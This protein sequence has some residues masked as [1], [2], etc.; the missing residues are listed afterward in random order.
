MFEIGYRIKPVKS[1]Q[2]DFEFFMTHAKDY[3]ALY[4]DSVNLNGFVASTDRPY[5]RMKY[6][7]IDLS[8]KQLGFTA[9]LSWV[10]SE[11][12][13]LN[14]YGTYQQSILN[15]VI[16]FSPDSAISYMITDAFVNY[17]ISG[18]EIDFSKRFPEQRQ[19]EV[20]NSWTPSFYGGM[21]LS[22]SMLK[23]KLNLNTNLYT[24]TSQTFK[25]KYSTAE[26]ASKVILNAR[27]SYKLYND[28]LSV[29]VNVR[30]LLD[31]KQEYAYMDEIGSLY[32]LGLT[33]NL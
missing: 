10:A 22:V 21:I 33:M 26:V 28:K 14:V 9:K 6:T 24:Y 2:A 23:K 17:S 1:V 27:L 18:G 25:S 5:V 31:K 4:P 32:L 20:K 15:N 3:G 11:N 29:F 13:V 30:N 12:I 8:S 16:P 7:N 19:D